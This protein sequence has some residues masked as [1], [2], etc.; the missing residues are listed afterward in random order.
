MSSIALETGLA[1]TA[2]PARMQALR[3]HLHP[4]LRRLSS[5]PLYTSW[6]TLDDLHLFLESNVFAV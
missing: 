1:T 6:T 3:A 2:A 4:L 5:H